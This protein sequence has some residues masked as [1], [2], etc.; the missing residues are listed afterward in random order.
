MDEKR[1]ILSTETPAGNTVH[2]FS[3]ANPPIERA[4]DQPDGDL[5]LELDDGEEIEEDLYLPLIMDA[6]IPHEP[7]PLTA[8]AVIVGIMLGCL[9]NASNLYLGKFRP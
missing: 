2:P 5:K 9:V 4:G 7:N 1:D 6:S 3:E 8:R